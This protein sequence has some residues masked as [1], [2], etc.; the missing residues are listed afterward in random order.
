V[1]DNYDSFAD[2]ASRKKLLILFKNL[3]NHMYSVDLGKKIRAAHDAK[4][5]RGEPAGLPPY[6]Y[7]RGNDGKSLI[8][9]AEA[10][11]IVRMVYGLRLAGESATAIARR[12]NREKVPSAQNLLYQRG[13]RTHESFSRRIVWT[14]TMIFKILANE[15]YTGALVNNKYR[16]DG[17]KRV[18]L[19]KDQ[20]IRHDGTHP[21]IISAEVF[22]TAR[23]LMSESSE[24]YAGGNSGGTLPENR[25]AGKLFCSRCGKAL[26]R[27]NCRKI[28]PIF[29]YVCRH[30]LNDLKD[31]LGLKRAP[32]FALDALD[33]AVMGTFR[34]QADAMLDADKLVESLSKSDALG[35][36][37]ARLAREKNRLEKAVNE[38][39]RR[40]SAA[41]THFLDGLLDAREFEIVRSGIEREKIDTQAE[42]AAIAEKLRR[43]DE[44]AKDYTNWRNLYGE[45][46]SAETPSREF[47]R[48]FISAIYVTPMT[49]ETRIVLNYADGLTEFRG[50]LE[51]G[52]GV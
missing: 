46:R 37:R 32:N 33:A 49:N 28:A 36:K 12:L 27:V 48:T 43:F 24:K 38:V 52:A 25:Y 9:D 50:L 15:T 20:W 8:I 39:D 21:A 35:Q 41:Y 45:F 1:S 16:C 31:E 19:P 30:C 2:D 51:S 10:A 40:F 7:L 26:T 4:K 34:A 11:G 3:V 23:K 29:Y 44:A 6:G 22:E 17:K 5:R 13:L 18:L 14:A 47:L 42:L